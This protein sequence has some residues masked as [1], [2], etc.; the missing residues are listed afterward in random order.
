MDM[1]FVPILEHIRI[2]TTIYVSTP[3]AWIGLSEFIHRQAR[4]G[5]FWDH[6][7]YLQTL[8]TTVDLSA[9]D[10]S[11]HSVV[12]SPGVIYDLYFVLERE[13]PPEQ[14]PWL[15]KTTSSRRA[16]IGIFCHN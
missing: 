11:G 14:R 3:D 2:P 13:L 9:V 15:W 5:S 1:E 8:L 10:G 16:S 7:V 4:V 6:S 12:F